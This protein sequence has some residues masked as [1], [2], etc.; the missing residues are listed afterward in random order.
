[1]P[2]S[3]TSPRQT[4]PPRSLPGKRSSPSAPTSSQTKRVIRVGRRTLKDCLGLPSRERLEPVM[5]ALG[6][7][8]FLQEAYVF[9]N[10]AFYSR[11]ALAC[12]TIVWLW[13]R[14]WTRRWCSGGLALCRG[15]VKPVLGTTLFVA[16][17]HRGS[18]PFD[19]VSRDF[20]EESLAS[21][22]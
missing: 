15:Q 13:T 9:Q 18:D 8:P 19:N 10:S 12:A 21:K 20:L 6:R 5:M 3:S 1:M 17:V 2:S 7:F 22:M 16:V 11:G 14:V 4:P